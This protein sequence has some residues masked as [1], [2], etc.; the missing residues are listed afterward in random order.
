MPS[1]F[2]MDIGSRIVYIRE[3]SRKFHAMA[4][5]SGVILTV[6]GFPLALD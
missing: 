1:G 5:M 2:W 4:G 6:G 3:Q